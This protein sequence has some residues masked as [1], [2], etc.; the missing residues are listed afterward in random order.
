MD[1]FATTNLVPIWTASAPSMKAAAIPL[2]SPMPPAAMTGIDT[3]STTCGT[4]VMVV[5]SPICPPDSVPSATT[6]SAPPRSISFARA[7]EA[8]TGITMIPASFHIFMYFAGFPAPVVTTFTP[9]ST[10]TFATS[11]AYGLINMT[12]TPN[13]FFVSAFALRISSRTTSPGAFAPPMR[14][15]PPASETAAAR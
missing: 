10:T 13:G 6:A 5:A 12:L 14:P 15:R 8:T 11:S 7:T 4:R 1:S 9:S 3:A 2:P